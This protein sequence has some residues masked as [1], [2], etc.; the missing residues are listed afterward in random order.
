MKNAIVFCGVLLYAIPA[1]AQ[2]P[3]TDFNPV[4]STAVLAGELDVSYTA[5]EQLQRKLEK[6]VFQVYARQ[7]KAHPLAESAPEFDGAAVAVETRVVKNVVTHEAFQ[8]ATPTPETGNP[9]SVFDRGLDRASSPFAHKQNDE[10]PLTSSKQYYLTTADWMTNAERIDIQIGDK[11]YHAQLEFRDDAQNVVIL[12]TPAM[13]NVKG[14]PLY[15]PDEPMPAL[16]FVLLNPGSPYESLTQHTLSVSQMHRYATANMTARNGY[17]LFTVRG[18][19]AGLC[20]GPA[21]AQTLAYV[22]HPGVLD[23]ALNP[24]KY[25]RTS[26]E[27]VDLTEY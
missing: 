12:S 23:R 2:R 17:P 20:V 22:V 19:L 27:N 10:T 6:S 1:V 18:E 5:R 26:L 13:T 11:K 4:A 16:V 25:D 21:P 3:A 7:P 15:N 9:Y 8:E 14:V 24:K